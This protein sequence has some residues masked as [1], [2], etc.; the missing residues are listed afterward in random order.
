VLRDKAGGWV[1]LRVAGSGQIGW[2]A[3]TLLT[4][5]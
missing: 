5:E 2:A 3:A 4:A 1:K